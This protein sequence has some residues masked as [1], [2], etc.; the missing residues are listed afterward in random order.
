M[1]SIECLSAK[2]WCG[3]AHAFALALSF[4]CSPSEPGFTDTAESEL[5]TPGQDEISVPAPGRAETPAEGVAT[6]PSASAL[7]QEARALAKDA[8]PLAAA[9]KYEEALELALATDDSRTEADARMGIGSSFSFDYPGR[10]GHLR[11]AAKIYAEIGN[12]ANEA[13]ALEAQGSVFNERNLN[14][15]ALEPL[16]RAVTL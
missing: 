5:A 7:I 8:Q 3:L 10:V 9:Q 1:F 13:A 2:T 6:N 14:S 12:F 15:Q 4:A 11:I 16:K